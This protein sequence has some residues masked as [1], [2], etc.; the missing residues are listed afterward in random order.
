M[1]G[2]GGEVYNVD[3]IKHTW[4]VLLRIFER[5]V[6]TQGQFPSCLNDLTQGDEVSAR[7][8]N[9]KVVQD[10]IRALSRSICELLKRGLVPPF[11]QMAFLQLLALGTGCT[12]IHP[13]I[14]RQ[15][16]DGSLR[17]SIAEEIGTDWMAA[18]SRGERVRGG[19]ETSSWDTEDWMYQECLQQ[20]LLILV[21]S[22]HAK[23]GQGTE[24]T[25]TLWRRGGGRSRSST[26]EQRADLGPQGGG[27]LPKP[28]DNFSAASLISG[29]AYGL[30]YSAREPGEDE[31]DGISHAGVNMNEHVLDIAAAAENVDWFVE[32]A[33]E[34]GCRCCEQA[35]SHF[36]KGGFD[37]S[38]SKQ[39][40]DRLQ[41][42]RPHVILK[43]LAFMT[44]AFPL[45]MDTPHSAFAS[46][47]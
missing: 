29:L 34:V 46:S 28:R 17:A 6:T 18:L 31:D 36:V 47:I 1:E 11:A 33:L 9:A 8:E 3:N 20:L 5:A 26:E 44:V 39:T 24:D 38:S 40:A 22:R 43:M 35:L 19:G 10:W 27:S 13:W 30:G 37:A 2:G 25:S 45:M 21:P 23:S 32:M 15:D 42:T 4:R 14:A 7:D 41:E 16:L 12:D